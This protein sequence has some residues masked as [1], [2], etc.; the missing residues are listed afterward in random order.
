MLQKIIE[1]AV[2]KNVWGKNPIANITNPYR[3][4]R[5][6]QNDIPEAQLGIIAVACGTLIMVLRL[7]CRGHLLEIP[8]S[9]NLQRS[10]QYPGEG[11]C[12][13]GDIIFI[14]YTSSIGEEMLWNFLFLHAK[15]IRD[16]PRRL[17]STAV[18]A[19]AKNGDDVPVFLLVIICVAG[20]LLILINGAI[21]AC[22]MQRKKEK[23]NTRRLVY[24][25]GSLL[26][27]RQDSSENA[28][29]SSSYLSSMNTRKN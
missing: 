2:I 10:L 6:A 25:D 13:S 23:T 21:V 1:L 5:V 7:S 19:L 12:K 22:Y 16:V 4:G 27:R 18:D 20:T 24:T 26:D 9:D 29:V 15:K 14:F 3:K 17:P 8:L 11:P 28:L